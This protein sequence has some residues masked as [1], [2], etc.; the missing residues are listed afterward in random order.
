MKDD[1][2]LEEVR[3][4]AGKPIRVVGNTGEAFIRALYQLEDNDE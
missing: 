2:T 1:M 4:K 3:K